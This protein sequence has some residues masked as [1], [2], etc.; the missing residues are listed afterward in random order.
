M[1]LRLLRTERAICVSMTGLDRRT[2]QCYMP[3]TTSSGG[4]GMVTNY[5]EGGATKWEGGWACEVLP[6]RKRGGGG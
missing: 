1:L 2:I 3:V 6:L 5:G 4:K